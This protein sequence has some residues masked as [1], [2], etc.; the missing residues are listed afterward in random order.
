MDFT[1]VTHAIWWAMMARGVAVFV[2]GFAS[3]TAWARVSTNQVTHLQ[4]EKHWFAMGQGASPIET[5]EM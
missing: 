1:R 3:N 5:F 4:Q 2:L